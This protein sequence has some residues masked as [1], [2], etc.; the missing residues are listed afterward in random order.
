MREHDKTLQNPTSLAHERSAS[1]AS[2]SEAALLSQ[3]PEDQLAQQGRRA[4]PGTSETMI[5][6]A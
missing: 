4:T 5:D 3:Y 6:S 1:G 2:R